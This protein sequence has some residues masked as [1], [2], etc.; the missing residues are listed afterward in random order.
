MSPQALRGSP[1]RA[2]GGGGERREEGP[3]AQCL[4]TVT[5]QPEPG[6]ESRVHT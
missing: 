6:T 4:V 1:P 3:V 2:E 5:P